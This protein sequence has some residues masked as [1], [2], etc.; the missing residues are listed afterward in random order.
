MYFAFLY[1][2]LTRGSQGK[3]RENSRWLDQFLA[4]NQLYLILFWKTSDQPL[5]QLEKPDV[6]PGVPII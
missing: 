3:I 1:Q 6:L 2:H 5:C 4:A